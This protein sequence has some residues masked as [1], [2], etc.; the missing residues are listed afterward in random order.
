[1]G[2][3]RGPVELLLRMPP[4]R[5]ARVVGFAI[6]APF[7]ILIGRAGRMALSVSLALHP[8]HWERNLSRLPGAF[9]AA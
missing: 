3:M 8:S 5:R 6:G 4:E 1:M 9:I 7:G 2:R